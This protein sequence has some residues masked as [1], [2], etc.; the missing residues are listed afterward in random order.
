MKSININE[1]NANDFSVDN[2]K[3]SGFDVIITDT[4]GETI[5]IVDGLPEL[6][7][8]N[9]KLKYANGQH[10]ESSDILTS[11]DVSKLGLDVAIL[12]RLIEGSDV[13]GEKTDTESPSTED[14]VGSDKE[15]LVKLLDENE[16][17]KK[18]L[19]E[20]ES[21]A[22]D[23]NFEVTS[24][25]IQTVSTELGG[26]PQVQKQPAPVSTQKKKLLLEEESGRNSSGLAQS[27]NANSEQQVKD[28]IQGTA[29]PLSAELEKGSNTGVKEDNITA[30]SQPVFT[31]M[32]APLAEVLLTIGGNI[33]TTTAGVD[34][35]WKITV[36]NP[37]PEGSNTYTVR[38]S[39]SNGAT[40]ILQ[41]GVI[42]DTQSQEVSVA[43]DSVTDTGVKG[44]F[45]TQLQTPTFSGTAEAEA[46]LLLEVSGHSYTFSADVSGRW[47]F[48][49][50]NALGEG[51]HNYILTST[52][53][54]GNITATQGVLTI[55]T[56]GPQLS[57]QLDASNNV[58]TGN[59][60]GN[61]QPT[62]S[63]STEPGLTV[64]ITIGDKTYHVVADGS[65]DWIFTVPVALENKTWEYT[66][67]ATDVA[68]NKRSIKDQVVIHHQQIVGSLPLTGGLDAGS[69]TGAT[70]D[71][72]TSVN[73]PVF[74]GTTAPSASV[75]VSIAGNDYTAIADRDGNWKIEVTNP[76]SDS[77]YDYTITATGANGET[78]TV[79]NYLIV[80]TKLPY[81]AIQIDAASDS[82]VK[83]DYIT[84][85]K[86]PLLIGTTEPNAIVKLSIQGFE[87]ETKAN[88]SGQWDIQISEERL[89][90]NNS[91]TVTVTDAAGNS[92][93]TTG[94][95]ILDTTG[96]SLSGIKFAD[97]Y[98]D[99]H[100][101]TYT[102]TISGWSEA[103][104][105]VY[106]KIGSRE[107]SVT[108]PSNRQWQFKVPS[109][110][111]RVGNEYQYITFI[112][113]DAAGN[114]TQQT[115]KFSFITKKPLIT[116]DISKD[117]DT[118]ILG[119]KITS[120]KKPTLTG[121]IDSPE[122]TARQ[123]AKA[124][125]TVFIDGRIYDNITVNENGK[126]SL[127][128]SDELANGNTYNY[129]ITV[130][131][132]VGN[133][134][135]YESYVTISTLSGALDSTSITGLGFD[136]VT[137]KNMPTLSGMANPNSKLK[138]TLPNI[139]YENIQVSSNGRWYYTI[140]QQLADG[141]HD[142][143]IIE[144]TEDG[145]TNKFFGYFYVDTRAPDLLSAEL[146]EHAPD[147]DAVSYRP[148]LTLKGETEALARVT[149]IVAAAGTYQTLANEKGEWSYTFD[150]D[151]FDKFTPYSYVVIASDA[152]GN[153]ISTKN[154]F[155]IDTINV[156]ASL[157]DATNSNH[158]NSNTPEINGQTV[159]NASIV[160]NIDSKEY[161][162]KA[163][164]NGHWSIKTDTL[165]DKE[166][167]YTVTAKL[168]NKVNY[169]TGNIVIDTSSLTPTLELNDDSGVKNN[170]ITKTDNSKLTGKTES[171]A[172]VTIKIKEK[173]YT[174]NADA[175][176]K[177]NLDVV[178]EEGDN[179][180]EIYTKD[181][182]GNQSKTVTGK[183]TLDLTPPSVEFNVV[184]KFNENIMTNQASPLLIG[185]TEPGLTVNVEIN[186]Q[187][188]T[189]SAGEDG[190]WA[191]KITTLNDSTNEY[192]VVVEDMAGNKTT[193]KGTIYLDTANPVIRDL[194]I[195]GA[196]N[197]T[198]TNKVIETR[199]PTIKGYL[200]KTEAS[201]TI[202]FDSNP[203]VYPVAIS[204]DN[205]QWSY[206]HIND[207]KPGM[208]SFTIT[209]VDKAGNISSYTDTF[210]VVS[211]W[212]GPS[213]SGD[214]IEMKTLAIEFDPVQSVALVKD[215]N[216]NEEML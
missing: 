24:E 28:A 103:G 198:S 135:T 178:L 56:T 25:P 47:S 170:Y 101:N 36:S 29:I 172:Q 214:H 163:D 132:F 95:F 72:I 3:V 133:T 100:S 74:T 194:T 46:T 91:Y 161:T 71:K 140:K 205:G 5:R 120:N 181:K 30:D 136:Q 168:D 54:A 157:R 21:Q 117:T 139:I 145:K 81:G 186:D 129:T 166:Y 144:A 16:S 204:K 177:W 165:S 124:K 142:Y 55:D 126:W 112:A 202:Q 108:V 199:M 62:F 79:N 26:Q 76:L 33:Y 160:L 53:K 18:Q 192:T 131:D 188:Y 34:G 122:Q 116:A 196:E 86:N 87:Y 183:L 179:N 58:L 9:T 38:A 162:T 123:I 45:T 109:G 125:V 27:K 88:S 90:E 48:T 114:R 66:V 31:G 156:T 69:D 184:D 151:E 78:G 83:G 171:G 212:N 10:I 169:V 185:K 15:Q 85:E 175:D 154:S 127:S 20:A 155:Y 203:Q 82:G 211:P 63:G 32:T 215:T 152:A 42:I 43:L 176:G 164:N 12:D 206:R 119:D 49:L 40:G 107:H 60:L 65:G 128:L 35:S 52:D 67:T 98:D 182:S 213:F 22:K 2:L 93:T 115:V 1:F 64:T 187:K 92:S 8:G 146:K 111:I 159:P 167:S 19:A 106:I 61:N 84:N 102:P 59:I 99:R 70:G 150:K 153:K 57:Q 44:D 50:P 147:N 208:H 41:G 39:S 105:T 110:F 104:S 141:K 143:S 17:L 207:F 190:S 148:D 118:D 180:Y 200:D 195:F 137:S 193:S 13:K 173:I 97:G 96:P 94:E 11:I 216:N 73:K 209:A 51:G 75:T 130:T 4:K 6:L 68:G 121:T 138:I 7:L 210:E 197:T 149:I 158:I 89:E 14:I 80:D 113:E 201:L 37:L 174:T 23:N 189:T 77:E 134:N 191:I